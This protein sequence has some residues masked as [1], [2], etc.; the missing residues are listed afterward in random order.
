VFEGEVEEMV[1]KA[2]LDKTNLIVS[3]PSPFII[4]ENVEGIVNNQSNTK[5][6]E[7]D[8]NGTKNLLPVEEFQI[9]T[10]SSTVLSMDELRGLLNCW[11]KE[12]RA[13]IKPD[14]YLRYFLYTDEY[15]DEYS[16][17]RFDSGKSFDNIFF[18]QKDD[19]I[20]RINFFTYNK[21][22]Y[23]K[24]GIPHTIG[25]MFYGVP[26]CGKTSTIKAM[27]NYT[28]RHIVSVPLSKIK[29]CK[30]LLGIFYNSR[31]NGKYIPLQ[32]RLYVLEDID[33]DELKH[34]VA[35]RKT[36]KSAS[37]EDCDTGSNDGTEDA[38]EKGSKTIDI[39]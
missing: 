17:Y 22:W 28:K 5:D 13:S 34:I 16:E 20:N 23:R 27:A 14:D 19:I 7:K 30:E 26:G 10:I 1:K 25:F 37:P 18:P 9:V 3:Q 31:I 36:K 12:Y 6:S 21:E 8:D 24:R 33:C 35:D 38:K 32:K 2:E 15:R 4:A 39:F 29:S 11:T